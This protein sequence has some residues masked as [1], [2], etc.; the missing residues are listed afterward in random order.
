MS[1]PIFLALCGVSTAVLVYVLVQFWRE[2]LRSQDRSGRATVSGRSSS[3]NLILVTYPVPLSA[4]GGISVMPV[5]APAPA[6]AHK[7]VSDRGILGKARVLEM[8]LSGFHAAQP[9]AA[10]DSKMRS[11]LNAS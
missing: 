7:S 3:A 9:E 4:Q 6:F 10:S 2:A 11:C 8:P 5:Q 1:I